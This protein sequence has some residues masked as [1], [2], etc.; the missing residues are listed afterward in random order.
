MFTI[1]YRTQLD[2][3]LTRLETDNLYDAMFVLQDVAVRRDAEL[4]DFSPELDGALDGLLD[5]V[6][7]SVAR[8][9]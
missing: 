1:V 5:H 3:T 7:L 9:L 4:I 2:S 6:R 8:A